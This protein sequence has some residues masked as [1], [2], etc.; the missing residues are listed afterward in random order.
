MWIYECAFSTL[1]LRTTNVNKSMVVN[2][3]SWQS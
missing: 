2:I 1:N 3:N